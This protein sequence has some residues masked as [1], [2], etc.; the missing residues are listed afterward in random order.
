MLWFV[1]PRLP[2]LWG[3]SGARWKFGNKSRAWYGLWVWYWACSCRERR[4]WR[5]WQIGRTYAPEVISCWSNN[6]QMLW[7]RHTIIPKQF[8]RG[9]LW[10]HWWLKLRFILH[11]TFSLRLSALFTQSSQNLSTVI[12]WKTNSRESKHVN[13]GELCEFKSITIN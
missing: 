3:E 9:M 4:W 7:Q 10:K 1:F 2:V 11:C 5:G 12:L 6:G 13:S 8:S